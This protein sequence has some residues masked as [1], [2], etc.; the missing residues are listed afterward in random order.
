MSTSSLW[1]FVFD[2]TRMSSAPCIVALLT[3]PG[4]CLS[5]NVICA[6]STCQSVSSPPGPR[7][8]PV[9]VPCQSSGNGPP[10]SVR[11]RS[12]SS[13]EN[14]ASTF[15]TASTGNPTPNVIAPV[16]CDFV[17]RM[18]ILLNPYSST[19]A[20]RTL[21]LIVSSSVPAAGARK[22][23]VHPRDVAHGQRVRPHVHVVVRGHGAAPRD[24]TL[25]VP[26][27]ARKIEVVQL[28]EHRVA[29]NPHR[30]PRVAQLER[31]I[32]LAHAHVADRDQLPHA[33][34]IRE[35]HVRR[36]QLALASTGASA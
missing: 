32:V 7:T 18:S 22:R 35:S 21:F 8:V 24:A 23:R 28:E 19:C 20:S 3:A 11:R 15:V 33:V 30:T 12:K 10:A 13:G 29:E 36:A 14:W 25:R 26:G 5:W 17:E 2:G 27:R 4:T 1:N 6:S 9:N 31:R 16:R 34:R